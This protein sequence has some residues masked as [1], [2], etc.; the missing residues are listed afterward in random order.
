MAELNGHL[1]GWR[2]RI[3]AIGALA[4]GRAAGCVRDRLV[5]D[6]RPRSQDA[7]VYADST[8]V[9]PEVSGRITGVHI[10]ENQRVAKDEILVE[11]EREPYEF[12]LAQARAAGCGAPG[13]DRGERRARSR[14]N[15]PRRRP[16]RRRSRRRAVA[17][18]SGEDHDG[19]PL[20]ARRTRAMR[21]RNNS[22]RRRPKRRS[23]KPR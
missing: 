12:K 15:R 8:S 13:A 20:S 21:R 16:P 17:T 4:R 14:R 19:A 2:G 22:M 18:R 1:A 3:L 5:S 7:F 23:R 10:R 6:R 9:V 11:I